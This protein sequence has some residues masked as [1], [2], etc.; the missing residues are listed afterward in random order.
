MISILQIQ[1]IQSIWLRPA[2]PS[3][4]V[5]VSLKLSLLFV[6]IL[7]NRSLSSDGVCS[8]C[9]SHTRKNLLT[10]NRGWTYDTHIFTMVEEHPSLCS[11]Q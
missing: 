11:M 10:L 4:P 7:L 8:Y 9:T 6:G 1:A 2:E 3:Y 5:T